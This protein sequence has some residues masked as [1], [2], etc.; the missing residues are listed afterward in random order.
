MYRYICVHVH[1]T[2][3]CIYISRYTYTC[4]DKPGGG[5]PTAGMAAILAAATAIFSFMFVHA[6][7]YTY[8]YVHIP[9]PCILIHT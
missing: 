2:C 7:A 8:S 6:H 3:L 9:S 4:L 1:D 5:H